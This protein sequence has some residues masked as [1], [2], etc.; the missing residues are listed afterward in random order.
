MYDT[1]AVRSGLHS[2]IDQIVSAATNNLLGQTIPLLA[3]D[4]SGAK[5]AILDPLDD[6]RQTLTNLVDGNS[7][8]EALATAIDNAALLGDTNAITGDV[9]GGNLEIYVSLSQTLLNT[10]FDLDPAASIGL[11]AGALDLVSAVDVQ[12]TLAANLQFTVDPGNTVTFDQDAVTDEL[13]LDLDAELIFPDASAGGLGFLPLAF[14]DNEQYATGQDPLDDIDLTLALDFGTGGPSA[15]LNGRATIDVLVDTNSPSPVLPELE[16]NLFAQF[17]YSNDDLLG[18]GASD[19]DLT[20]ELRD[21]LLRIDILTDVFIDIFDTIGDIVETFPID[22]I[23]SALNQ[24]LPIVDDIAPSQ[25]DFNAEGGIQIRDV[26]QFFA[27]QNQGN[28]ALDFL[29]ALITITDIATALGNLAETLEEND[30]FT[31][32]DFVLTPAA[33][34]DIEAGNVF[35]ANDSLVDISGSALEDLAALVALLGDFGPYTGLGALDQL[36]GLETASLTASSESADGG[37]SGEFRVLFPFLAGPEEI[38]QSVANILLNGFGAPPVTLIEA[39]FPG[40]FFDVSTYLP[41][42]FGPFVGYFDGG[43]SGALDINIGYDT[44]GL[45]FDSFDFLE[46][47]FIR[48]DLPPTTIGGVP[49]QP[50][51]DLDFSA[52][53]GGGLDAIVGRAVVE[54]GLVGALDI[55][56]GGT[57]GDGKARLAELGACFFDE[58]AGDLN[59]G[60]DV[61]FSVGFGAFKIEKRI[62]LGEYTL[63]NFGIDPCEPK[64]EEVADAL[65]ID[66][67]GFAFVD[68]S[69]VLVLNVGS[70]ASNREINPGEEREVMR[71]GAPPEDEQTPAAPGDLAVSAFGAFER[72]AKGE[73]IVGILGAG[74]TENDYLQIDADVTL[75]AT[76]QG[77]LGDDVLEGGAADDLLEGDA[78]RDSLSGGDGDDALFGGSD[79]DFLDGGAGADL[80]DGGAGA[81]DQLDFSGSAVGVTLAPSLFNPLDPAGTLYGTGGEAE[82]DTVDNVEYFVGSAFDDVFYGNPFKSNT[83]EGNAGNDLLVGGDQPD[84][85]IGGEGADAL[86]GFN[87]A[88][89]NVDSAGDATSYIFSDAGVHINRPADLAF[90]G[91]AA[92]DTFF[93]IEDF[94]LSR[95]DDT[96]TGDA[97]ANMV[98]GFDGNDRLSGGGGNDEVLGGLGDDTITGGADT[99]AGELDADRLDGGGFRNF[100]AGRD[101][102]SYRDAGFAVTVDLVAGEAIATGGTTTQTLVE[103]LLI[104]LTPGPDY[105]T[106]ADAPDNWGNFS[107]FEEVEGSAFSDS[108]TGDYNR[109]SLYGLGGADTIDGGAGWDTLI[110]G[111]GADSLDGGTGRDWADYSGSVN[112]VEVNLATGL[113]S[114]GDAT[115]DTLANIENLRGSSQADALTGDAGDNVLDPVFGGSGTEELDGGAGADTAIIDISGTGLLGNPGLSLSLA[116]DGSG[117]AYRTSDFLTPIV[118]M[119][120][121]ENLRVYTARGDD[122]IVSANGGDDIVNTGGGADNIA[123]GGGVDVVRAGDGDD[124][125]SRLGALSQTALTF[126]PGAAGLER[127]FTLDGGAGFDTLELDLSW[128]SENITLVREVPPGG[129]SNSVATFSNG[130]VIRNFEA[131]QT[132]VAGT[133][134][135]ILSQLGDVSSIFAGNA[136]A[137]FIATGRGFDVADGGE[138]S[139]A[140]PS[141]PIRGRPTVSYEV[142]QVDEDT[143][144]YT[145][146]SIDVLTVSHRGETRLAMD[147]ELDGAREQADGQSI[148]RLVDPE[149]L[150][151]PSAAAQAQHET[152]FAHFERLLLTGTERGDLLTGLDLFDGTSEF[153]EGG[154]VL[155]GDVLDGAG[156]DDTI[157][158]QDGDDRLLGGEGNDAVT[159]G[160]GDDDLT[161]AQRGGSNSEADTLTGGAG[162][163]LFRLGDGGGLFGDQA[164]D[165]VTIADFSAGEGDRIVLPGTAGDYVLRDAG[166]GQTWELYRSDGTGGT[167]VQIAEIVSFEALGLG[168]PAFDYVALAPLALTTGPDTA[169]SPAFATLTETFSASVSQETELTLGLWRAGLVDDATAIEAVEQGGRTATQAVPPTA[170]PDTPQVI[171]TSDPSARL[172]EIVGAAVADIAVATGEAGGEPVYATAAYQGH[173]AAAGLFDEAFDVA[174][175]VVIGTGQVEDIAGPNSEDGAGAIGA[176]PAARVDVEFVEVGTYGGG[177]RTLYRAE[178]PAEPGGIGA[179][180][181]AD[182]GDFAPGAGGP[183]SGFDL[184][185]LFLSDT[186]VDPETDIALEA[187]PRLDALDLSQAGLWFTPGLSTSS[188]DTRDLIGTA[189]GDVLDPSAIRLD[190]IDAVFDTPGAERGYLSL[191]EGGALTVALREPL[192]TS[193]AAVTYL[194][195]VE[196]GGSDRLENALTLSPQTLDLAGDFSTDLAAPGAE[197]DSVRLT[198]EFTIGGGAAGGPLPDI[199]TPGEIRDFFD[200]VLVTEELPERAG[201]LATD[202]VAVKVNGVEGLATPTGGAV[203][204]STLAPTPYGFFDP[205]LSLNLL[206]EGELSAAIAADAYATAL[207]VS[208]PVYEG[209]NR[210]EITVSD[211]ADGLLDTALFLAPASPEPRENAAPLARPDLLDTIETAPISGNLLSGQGA[212]V[213]PEGEQLH[214]VGLTLLD[215]Q[216]A[217]V[218]EI[219][220]GAGPVA[221]AD[222]S[223]TLVAGAEGD[224]GFTPGPALAPLAPGEVRALLFEARVADAAGAEATSLLTLRIGGENSAPSLSSSGAVTLIDPEIGVPFAFEDPEGDTLT[225]EIAGGADAALFVLD[226]NGLRFATPPDFGLLDGQSFEVAVRA[227]DSEGAEGEATLTVMLQG[228]DFV[229]GPDADTFDGTEA[230]EV[231]EGRGGALLNDIVDGGGG[232]DTLRNGDGAAPLSLAG[233]NDAGAGPTGF[234]ILKGAGGPGDPGRTVL[235]TDD[236]NAFRLGGVTLID[237]DRLATGA[238]ADTVAL[239][240]AIGAEG[241]TVE[242]GPGDDTVEGGDAGERAEGGDGEDDLSGGA[243]DDSLDG[244]AGDDRLDGGEGDDSVTGGAGADVF[245][246]RP[247]DGA[248]FVTDFELGADRL[249]LSAFARSDVA[250]ALATATPGS[251]VLTLSDGTVVTVA[252]AGVAPGSLVLDDF[253]L[254]PNAVPTGAVTLSGEALVGRTLTADPSALADLDGLGPFSYAWLRDGTPISDAT[255]A[256]YVLRADDVG[257]EVAVIVSW[258][259]GGETLESVESTPTAPVAGSGQLI[260]GTPQPDDLPGTMGDDTIQGIAADDTLTGGA[261]DDSLDG[262]EGTDAAVFSGPR[263]AHTV[264]ISASGVSVEDRRAVGD[265]TDTLASIERIDFADGSWPIDVFDGVAGLSEDVFREF[266]EVYLA[267]FD[268]APDAEGLFFYGTAFAGGTTLREAASTFITSSEYAAS[269]PPEQSN[270]A[271]AT[272]VYENVLG[273]DPDQAGL[274]FWVPLLDAGTVTRDFFIVEV[275]KGAKAPIPDDANPA[276]RAQK[277]IDQQYLED[278][279]D[280]GIYFAVTKGMSNVTNAESAMDLFDGT[281]ASVDAAVSAIDTFHTAALDAETGEF[282]LTLVGVADD[283]LTV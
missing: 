236:A 108:I 215:A 134:D 87:T 235:G 200:V 190:R 260:V 13:V 228:P 53:A 238:G 218:Q 242:A 276:F 90:G 1:N 25:F 259:D 246:V 283:P 180:T 56:L 223:G 114:A 183:F 10:G 149:N 44:A 199:F 40:L 251:A 143:T 247:G 282:I 280:I 148:V 173:A 105:G 272:T 123:M 164:G 91:H 52:R 36:D 31:L 120:G 128:E 150:G 23:V 77:G 204:L 15:S 46:G 211:G 61:L 66:E 203:S 4:L 41:L 96:F 48:P 104:E 28:A 269:Y 6:L 217:P 167:G 206:G 122:Q 2:A 72:F 137:D 59:V 181:F 16:T 275:L 101:L 27:A 255:G 155:V 163:D 147:V 43:I 83:F 136:G 267:Y 35:G 195:V 271:F 125:V 29:D 106:V 95:F 281:P 154:T 63:V 133:G 253:V 171:A 182:D 64:P 92:G 14:T 93:A 12:S 121:I 89:S 9:V 58:I 278:K 86:R 277:L 139:D 151:L 62:G 117:E 220:A 212:D 264:T 74:G 214:L 39:D 229:A 219:A 110:G 186:L 65:E 51:A 165:L 102:L 191:G 231:V 240:G 178:L 202:S 168:E 224:V 170:E 166:D 198:A 113:G 227:I 118:T 26:V 98:D 222:G 185:A 99:Q 252:G 124:S 129:Q 32:G 109:N 162:A 241:L 115:G 78:G 73:G 135:D 254:A 33:L 88:L 141:A 47:F 187:I 45:S 161:G 207:R 274:D 177:S 239:I 261:G 111:V 189:G 18:G 192:V 245:I 79:D 60:L 19:F 103:A 38:V 250:A 256:S 55:F 273:R 67:A 258:T 112:R 142:E 85:L 263:T 175:G 131:L 50:V 127:S 209:L 69:D 188:S 265:G 130:G 243:G 107:S 24:R 17:D 262:G 70:L 225:Y 210:I 176:G 221:L 68:A 100:Y 49:K 266:V 232:A 270:L 21:V 94:Q 81:F 233:F 158:G 30:G 160:L 248:T 37:V 159:G 234:E 208:G 153:V 126:P 132:V 138:D 152:R 57:E 201:A 197:G 216:G 157:D 80:I 145:P 97:G 279:T 7:T 82:G 194:Y 5:D 34:A 172:A 237:V 20:L 193:S 116:S 268:R 174:G 257:A 213:D 3:Q 71:V 184:D 179:L 54:G 11:P 140:P 156:G 144:V 169:L 244:G 196:A 84:M 75:E 119:A 146:E 205:A 8:L 249:D 42:Q 76:L 230:D 226:G 22:K